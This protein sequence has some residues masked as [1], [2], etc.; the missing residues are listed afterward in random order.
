MSFRVYY[1]VNIAIFSY[2]FKKVLLGV[3]V[4]CLNFEIMYRTNLF[5]RMFIIII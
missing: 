4:G 5:L 3:K 2:S 1:S